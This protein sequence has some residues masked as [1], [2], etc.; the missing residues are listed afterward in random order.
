M[1]E[2]LITY[3]NAV[4]PLWR[5]HEGSV[6]H[7]IVERAFYAGYKAGQHKQGKGT[8]KM[9]TK[10]QVID[11]AGKLHTR[12]TK[13]RTYT[14]AVVVVMPDN[15]H[16]AWVGRADLAEKEARVWRKHANATVEIIEARQV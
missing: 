9:T 2:E 13:A 12:T 10:Y 7:G 11:S 6:M 15:T 4:W 5:Q 16:V 1:E 3:L 14:H 8:N